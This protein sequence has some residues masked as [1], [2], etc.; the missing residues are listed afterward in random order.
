VDCGAWSTYQ[1]NEYLGNS[2][3]RLPLSPLTNK[4]FVFISAALREKSAVLFRCMPT[5]DYAGDVFE[6]FSNLC[7]VPFKTFQCSSIHVTM[8]SLM[9]FLNGAALAS[10]WIFFEHVDK[11]DYVHLQTFNKEIQMVQ[12]QFIIA[13]LSQEG[14]DEDESEGGDGEDH[15][16]KELPR[17]TEDSHGLQSSLQLMRR[18]GRSHQDESNQSVVKKMMRM[19]RDE[20]NELVA[21]SASNAKNNEMDGYLQISESFSRRMRHQPKHQIEKSIPSKGSLPAHE[22]YEEIG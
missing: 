14:E 9:Q 22:Y 11:L 7:C 3:Q 19:I 16:V 6:E 21:G 12:Q 2:I 15:H 4:Y 17:L 18:T 13:E 1:A 20:D 8:K 5:H 10:S